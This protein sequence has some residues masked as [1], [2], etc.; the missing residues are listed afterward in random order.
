[1]IPRLAFHKIRSYSIASASPGASIYISTSTSPHFNLSVEDWSALCPSSPCL[2]NACAQVVSKSSPRASFTPTLQKRVM[3]CHWE[4]S[5]ICSEQLPAN[6]QGLSCKDR[7]LGRKSTFQLC[8][9]LASHSFEDEVEE[10]PYFMQV[11]TSIVGTAHRTSIFGKGPGQ[12][13]F[14]DTFVS[15]SL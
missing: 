4:K 11:F 1:M 5:G 14:L 13:K 7:I 9:L 2:A 12:H 8:A 6:T 3:C 10:A 15:R